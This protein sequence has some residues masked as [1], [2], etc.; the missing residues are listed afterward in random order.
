VWIRLAGGTKGAVVLVALATVARAQTPVD[1]DTNPTTA[2]GLAIANA[3]PNS[4]LA[5]KGICQQD[6][7][8]A[9]ATNWGVT[10]TNDTGNTGAALVP[11]DGVMGELA[12]TGPLAVAINGIT[13][14]GTATDEGLPA[15]VVLQNGAS[16]TIAN[17][18]I[19]NAQRVGLSLEAATATVVN[20]VVSGNGIALATNASDGIH[21]V[22]GSHL[23]F[24]AVNGDGS[25]DA[26]DAVTVS[27]NMGNGLFIGSDS[28]LVMTGGSIAGNA[29]DQ[30]LAAGS[31]L[32]ALYGTSVSQ[33]SAPA[34]PGSFAIQGI[35]TTTVTLGGG[36]TVTAGT[37]A[38]G[39]QVLNASALILLGADISND[40]K[41]LPT[42]DASGNSNI[43]L[44]GGNQIANSA[45]AGTAIEVDHE[46]SL[47]QT[48]SG[49]LAS[50]MTTGPMS[51]T[52]SADTIVGAGTAQMESSMDVGIG[53]LSGA[54]SLTW[55]G[56][57]AI[58]QNSIFRMSGGATID[59]VLT[60]AQG[61]NGY[62][63]NSN[64]GT[65]NVVTGGVT[66]PGNVAASHVTAGANTV[67]LAPGSST[68]AVTFGAAPPACS[69]F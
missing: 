67:L 62:F 33:T 59:G 40:S 42:I 19:V 64:G 16:A 30:I 11:T 12:V 6:V 61:S 18:Q 27:G 5:I 68:S 38:G 54:A 36:A 28:R 13:L 45:A 35:G 37:V 9:M 4:V 48:L 49:E 55:T 57:V 17:A 20:S 46:A 14:E 69:S 50:S 32:V 63:N 23:K 26:S 1:C 52:P 15:N 25:I 10:L 56:T 7:T 8:I 39:V 21:A 22:G 31:A 2:L 60:L 3:T 44:A 53:F 66:C 43:V 29:G 58:S 51:A 24:G 41:T 47:L 34:A 65:G